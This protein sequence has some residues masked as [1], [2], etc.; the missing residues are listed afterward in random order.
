MLKKLGDLW[1]KNGSDQR[2]FQLLSNEF[3][4]DVQGHYYTEDSQ[5]ESA[6]DTALNEDVF[7]KAS[8]KFSNSGG[9]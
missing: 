2:F 4:L 6:I 7:I 9:Y 1:I 5:I 8:E 3:D